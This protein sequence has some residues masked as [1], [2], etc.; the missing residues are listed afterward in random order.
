MDISKGKMWDSGLEGDNSGGLGCGRQGGGCVQRIKSSFPKS[1][2][3][4]QTWL[5]FPQACRWH[6][7]LCPQASGWKRN[8]ERLS[9]FKDE[10]QEDLPDPV[11]SLA[12]YFQRKQKEW[13]SEEEGREEEED[14]S[15][16][17]DSAWKANSQFPLRCPAG[18]QRGNGC[19]GPRRSHTRYWGNPGLFVSTCVTRGGHADSK[20]P[21][22][23]GACGHCC[24][25]TTRP[26]P[27]F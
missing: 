5:S 22:R 2:T 17:S 8:R 27:D 1:E 21:P 7:S 23:G 12:P 20:R 9:E 11:P 13:L 26:S 18:T 6:P 4:H 16:C 3:S 19:L 10:L 14:M 25:S 15:G 24:L